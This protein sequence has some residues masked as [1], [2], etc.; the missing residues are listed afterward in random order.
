MWIAEMKDA[1]WD[2][3]P[4]NRKVGQA[5]MIRVYYSMNAS[6]SACM[7]I[8]VWKIILVFRRDIIALHYIFVA[9]YMTTMDM[10]VTLLE[11]PQ[12]SGIFCRLRWTA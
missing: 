10:A 4:Y 6:F 7:Q 11:V 12:I 1:S 5:H 3:R 9:N 8:S 2:F